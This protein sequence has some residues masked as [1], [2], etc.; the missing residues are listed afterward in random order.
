MAAGD[1]GGHPAPPPTSGSP[2]C[3]KV[4]VQAML[5]LMAMAFQPKNEAA[6]SPPPPMLAVG[7]ISSRVPARAGSERADSSPRRQT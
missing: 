2:G 5:L 3:E 6:L 7:G 4:H 1:H